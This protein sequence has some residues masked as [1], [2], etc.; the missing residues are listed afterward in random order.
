MSQKTDLTAREAEIIRILKILE[1]QGENF[2]VFGGYA[3]NALTSHRFSVDCDIVIDPKALKDTGTILAKEGYTA[4][5]T[6][7]QPAYRVKMIKYVKPIGPGKVSVELFPKEVSSRDTDGKWSFDLV[8]ANSSKLRVVGLTDSVEALVPKREL[9]MAM[10]IHAGRQT[11]LRDIAMLSERADWKVV[12]EFA[13]CGNIR[14]VRKQIES[15]IDTIGKPEFSSSLKAEFGLRY[16]VAPIIKRTL[17][18][19]RKVRELFET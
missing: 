19:L 12:N 1:P 14:K 16:D 3:I 10:K 13:L 11:D 2:V 9:V 17:E 15:A 18:G 4:L 6:A 7:K 8:K 5:T